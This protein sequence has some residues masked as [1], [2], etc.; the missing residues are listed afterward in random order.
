MKKLFLEVFVSLFWL[1]S[2]KNSI[3]DNDQ[4]GSNLCAYENG[5]ERGLYLV[6]GFCGRELDDCYHYN[7]DENKWTQIESLPRKLSVFACS[8]VDDKSYDGKLRLILH[9][10]EVDPSTLGRI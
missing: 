5:T 6:G 3:L 10:G 2:I 1:S 8:A 4:G 7:I 9:G